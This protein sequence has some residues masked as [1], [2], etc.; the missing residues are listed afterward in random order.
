MAFRSAVG[1]NRNVS[2]DGV[3]F[4]LGTVVSLLSAWNATARGSNKL[5]SEAQRARSKT[6]M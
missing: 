6:E 4:E 2:L 3:V 5:D 1:L